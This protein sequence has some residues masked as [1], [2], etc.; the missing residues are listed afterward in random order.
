MLF[1]SGPIRAFVRRARKSLP[2]D[3]QG[4]QLQYVFFSKA[5]FTPAARQAVPGR[6]CQWIGLPDLDEIL[7]RPLPKPRWIKIA[8]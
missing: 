7:R 8:F 5:G 4:A 6:T 2:S 1:R 3:L